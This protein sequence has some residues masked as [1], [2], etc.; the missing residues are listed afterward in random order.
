M[1]VLMVAACP[2]PTAGG[3]QVLIGEMA[4]ALARAGVRVELVTYGTGAG[5]LAAHDVACNYIVHRAPAVPGHRRLAAGPS[6][7]RPVADAGLAA[8]ATSVTRGARKSG[9]PFDLVHA[10]N[11]EGALAGAIAAKAAGLPLLYHAHNLMGDELETYFATDRART[12]ARWI[13]AALDR[14]VPRLG[15]A[16]VSVSRHAQAEL[17]RLT[18]GRSIEYQPPAVRYGARSGRP[19]PS[20]VLYAGNLDG[21]QGLDVLDSAL[22]RLPGVTCTVVSRTPWNG[23]S[24]VRW[25]LDRGFEEVKPYLEGARVAVLPRSVPSGFPVKLVNY[26][27]AGVP[28][29][30]CHGGAQGLGPEDGVWVVRDGDAAEFAEAI[31]A[32]LDDSELRERFAQRAAVAARRYGWE[33]HVAQLEEMYAGVVASAGT[34]TAAGRTPVSHRRWTGEV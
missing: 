5:D 34:R 33:A 6:W 17:T 28:V 18:G 32:L 30:A 27:C 12:V 21:Y 14:T 26:L 7:A 10:H 15:D 19:V 25:V 1:N 13:G 16:T 8:L 3:T 11:Y 22:A 24:S 20:Q 31:R 23:R 2:Y 9:R 4:T 29:V